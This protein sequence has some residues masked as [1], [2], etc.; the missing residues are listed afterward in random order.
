M[1]INNNWMKK[2]L[3]EKK[4]MINNN[5]HDHTQDNLA[6]PQTKPLLVPYGHL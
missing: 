5:C 1:M 6:Y 3:M 2:T 4:K